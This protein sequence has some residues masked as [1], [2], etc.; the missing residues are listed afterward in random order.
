MRA[1]CAGL[2]TARSTIFGGLASSSAILALRSGI[3]AAS[4]SSDCNRVIVAVLSKGRSTILTTGFSTMVG[5]LASRSAI[6]ARSPGMSAASLSSDLMRKRCAAFSLAS[7]FARSFSPRR[8]RTSRSPP[9]ERA[10]PTMIHK[11]A[12]T[13]SMR[14]SGRIPSANMKRADAGPFKRRSSAFS[15][16]ARISLPPGEKRREKKKRPGS[17]PAFPHGGAIAYAE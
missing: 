2:S 9:H 16:Q 14:T 12:K 4:F 7:A 3:L 11:I 8:R 10:A 15:P 5:G 17:L 6:F 13:H 1:R